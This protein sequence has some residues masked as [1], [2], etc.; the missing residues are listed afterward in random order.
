MQW[1]VVWRNMKGAS[2]V[3]A[4]NRHPISW[5]LSSVKTNSLPA[6]RVPPSMMQRGTPIRLKLVG[7]VARTMVS[8]KHGYE[9]QFIKLELETVVNVLGA[10]AAGVHFFR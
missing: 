9:S 7:H 4:S 8:V 6:S 5:S 2:L 10:A 1:M 3:I